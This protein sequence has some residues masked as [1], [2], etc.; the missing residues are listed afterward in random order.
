MAGSGQS[1]A[2]GRGCNGD[3]LLAYIGLL[4]AGK[5]IEPPQPQHKRAKKNTLI[6]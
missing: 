2:A 1:G 3:T 5:P 6:R 4:R